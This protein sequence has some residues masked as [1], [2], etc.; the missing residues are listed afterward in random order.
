MPSHLRFVAI[1]AALLALA[2][3][4]SAQ[5]PPA[6]A[7]PDGLPPKAMPSDLVT[8][9][10]GIKVADPYR[11]LE[12]VQAPATRAWYEAQHAFT[13]QRLD[14][15]PG[16]ARLRADI[17]A[18]DRTRTASVRNLRVTQKG[19]WFYLKRGAGEN[20]F[21]LYRRANGQ[22]P[23]QLFFDP[24]SGSTPGAIYAINNFSVAPDARHIALV[25][26]KNDAELGE[27][28]V[29]RVATRK[30]VFDPIPA[31]WGENV[32]G[33]SRDGRHVRIAQGADAATPGG[34]A[35]GRMRILERPLAG[36]AQRVL[37]GW[38]APGSAEVRERD[39]PS[40]DGQ[41][42][43]RYTVLMTYEG[44]AGDGRASFVDSRA[45][46]R[47]P[48]RA[49]WRP[50]FGAD[51]GAQEAS[52]WHNMLYVRTYKD[53][54]RFRIVRYDLRRP[55]VAPVE[56]VPQ[57]AGVIDGVAVAA[58]GIYYTV[59]TGAAAD[60]FFLP[61]GAK[62]DRARKVALPIIG[63]VY[64]YGAD[65]DVFGVIVSAEGW[66][67]E[68]RAYR[69]LGTQVSETDLI[70]PSGAP[71]G[72]DWVAEETTCPSHDGV[73]VPMSLIH[74][75]GLAK[76]GR[77]PVHL[78]GY[79]GY[80]IAEAAFFEPRNDAW[81]Q[82]GG[83]IAIVDPRGGGAYGQDWYQ[84]GVGPRKS[85]TWKDMIACAQA[86]I[87]RGYTSAA[88]LAIDG[89][90]MGGVAAGRAVT[91]RPD[92]FGAAVVQV[93]FT[94]TLR[95]I[96]ATNNGPNHELEMGSLKDAEQ[97]K[98]LLAMSTYHHV[99]DGER[100]P[101]MLFTAGL[102]DLRTAPWQAFKTFAR[103]SAATS[104]GR[105]MLLR[106]E[107]EGG[108]GVSATAQQ[109]NAELADRWAFLLWTLGHADFQ[110]RP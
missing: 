101:A 100:Y 31:I 84:A 5:Q 70:A 4:V 32:A 46:Q 74:R 89:R 6:T 7:T 49:P 87:D 94:D 80:G 88:K 69:V 50:L 43:P 71:V 45:L 96:E 90:S 23:E 14:A 24:E 39:W 58:D 15:L 17:D 99:R 36:G 11:A 110:P 21:K 1:A 53:A 102:N 79:G 56:M 44:V 66:T 91:E 106:V 64:F 41:S 62:P 12:D 38:N 26:A 93:G 65:A 59:R 76:D 67:R 60:L 57:Q 95:L 109:R 63:S 104:S 47:D 16:L 92:L 54:S 35:F 68:R 103:L 52:V 2:G 86:L 19:Q 108:H 30:L 105:P 73:R 25:V 28:R 18:L 55:D 77:N 81:L 3:A 83:V 13:R 82:R 8:D 22:A 48:A 33:W 61:H 75:R 37:V 51:A 29:Y 9:Y 97:V 98:Q 72:Q 42:S 78:R 10:H 85:N 40:V 20:V 107:G 27:L 34:R